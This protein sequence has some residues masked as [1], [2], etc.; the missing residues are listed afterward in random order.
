MKKFL[1]NRLPRPEGITSSRYLRFLGPWIA[2]PRLWHMHRRAVALGIAIGLMTGLIPGPIQ[3]L[4]AAL[5]AIPLRA[6]IPA[7]MFATLYTNPLTFV[8][9]YLLAYQVGG[10]VTGHHGPVVLPPDIGFSPSGL[11][12]AIPELFHWFVSLGDTLLIGLA[13]Q[14]SVTAICGYFL[15]LIVWRI[16]VTRRWRGRHPKSPLP[17]AQP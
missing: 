10:L 12:N 13:I 11:W 2:H 5:I 3:M 8:P 7:A 16:V 4:L 17:P 15:T 9:L 6:N 14:A 1:K